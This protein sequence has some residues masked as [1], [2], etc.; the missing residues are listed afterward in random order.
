M[1]LGSSGAFFCPVLLLVTA[2]EL[3]GICC[4]AGHTGLVSAPDVQHAQMHMV[5]WLVLLL[6]IA[7]DVISAPSDA[8]A[9]LLESTAVHCSC[10]AL[11]HAPI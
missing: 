11:N 1:L 5:S 8:Q 9:I 4:L 2:L 3:R 6:L 10:P 7:A